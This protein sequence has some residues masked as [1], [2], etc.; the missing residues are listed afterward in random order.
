MSNECASNLAPRCGPSNFADSSNKVRNQHARA[1]V[2]AVERRIDHKK[3][4]RSSIQ[5]DCNYELKPLARITEAALA[6]A[7]GFCWR[8][9]SQCQKPDVRSGHTRK[10]SS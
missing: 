8:D 1:P 5:R 6:I 4:C 3:T 10:Q 2:K 7:S 9:Q